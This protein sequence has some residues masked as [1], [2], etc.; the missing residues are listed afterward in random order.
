MIAARGYMINAR[1]LGVSDE[2]LYKALAVSHLVTMHL[3]SDSPLR[4]L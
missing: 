1:E 4:T 3:K 2:Q